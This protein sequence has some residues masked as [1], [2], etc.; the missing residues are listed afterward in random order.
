MPDS[1]SAQLLPRWRIT[2]TRADG[3]TTVAW[4]RLRTINDLIQPLA[5]LQFAAPT[6]GPTTI[7]IALEDRADA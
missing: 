2:V 3:Q 4:I 7:R 6:C 1:P 5:G